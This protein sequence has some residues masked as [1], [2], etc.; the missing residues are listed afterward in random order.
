MLDWVATLVVFGVLGLQMVLVGYLSSV[1]LPG[2]RGDFIMELPPLRWP[3]PRNVLFKSGHQLLWFL[4]EAI[5]YF[6]LGTFALFLLDKAGMITG[7]REALRPV[8]ESLLGLPSQS[9]DVFLLTILRREAGAALLAKQAAAGLYDGVQVV[10]T[11]IVMT[12]MIPCFNTVLIMY[13]ERGALTASLMLAFVIVY[14]LVV[15]GVVNAVCH[16]VG[17]QF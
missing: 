8:A 5:P 14:S 12:L 9:A 4:R 17:A 15:G 16:A 11:V 6:I 7:F 2:R 13:K 10:V 3:S 1:L